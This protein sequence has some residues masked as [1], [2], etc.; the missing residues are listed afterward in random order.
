MN[1]KHQRPGV[2]SVYD[3]SSVSAGRTGG[4]AAAV[5]AVCESGT[6]G[7]VY[8]LSGSAQAAETFSAGAELTGLIELLF[9]NG[10]AK[11]Y[12][13]P[14]AQGTSEEE[15]AAGYA[16]AFAALE[17]VEDVAVVVCDSAAAAVQQKLRDSVKAAS[18][19]RRERLA[20][21]CGGENEAV[22]ALTARAEGLNCER[23]VLA[24]PGGAKAAAAVAGAI[25]GETDPAMPLG[26][27][28][29]KGLDGLDRQWSDNE[30]DALVLGGVTPLE[31]VGGTVSVIRAVTTRTKTGDAADPT[32]RELSTIRVVDDVIP[33]LRRALR[34]KFSRAKNTAQGRGAI[35]SQV[36]VELENKL[37]DEIITGYDNVTVTALESDPTVCLVDFRFNVAHG[38]NQI[39]LQAH[40]TV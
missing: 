37:R 28:E 20:V 7:K 5:A 40:I 3:A 33:S 27:A 25:A 26:G 36:I 16:A 10:A 1:V 18:E 12:A 8:A 39:W 31:R 32:W 29:L 15:T 19:S 23:V 34:A 6:A 13:V 17:Q 24:A 11:V 4:G 9:A 35:R 14:V 38:L 21:V 2:Y 30:V 22:E